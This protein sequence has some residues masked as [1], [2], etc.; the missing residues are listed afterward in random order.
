MLAW[1]TTNSNS[2]T[3]SLDYDAARGKF[4]TKDAVCIT[5]G[6]QDPNEDNTKETM[7]SS[8][9]PYSDQVGI[10]KHLRSTTAQQLR[11]ATTILSC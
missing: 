2:K 1:A 4:T 9:T 5:I 10:R 7:R 11:R 6:Y 8:L 3:R